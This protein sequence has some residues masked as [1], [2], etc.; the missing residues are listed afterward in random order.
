MANEQQSGLQRSRISQAGRLRASIAKQRRRRKRALAKVSFDGLALQWLAKDLRSDRQ[1]VLAAVS[2][3]GSAL[4]WAAKALRSDQEIV[5]AAV[6]TFGYALRFAAKALMSDRKIVL[7]AVSNCGFALQF[8]KEQLKSDREVVLAAV[9]ESGFALVFAS[10]ELKR[11]REI[12]LA[13][14][15]GGRAGDHGLLHADD[16]LLEDDSFA[17]EARQSYYSFRVVAL[18]GRTCLV[19]LHCSEVVALSA[20][21]IY[22]HLMCEAR[23]KLGMGTVEPGEETLLFGAE[24][25][26]GNC[27]VEHWPGSPAP[28]GVVEYQLVR[29]KRA[30]TDIV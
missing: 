2:N 11:D 9:S 21:D 20:R 6:S 3:S 22:E 30:R 18:S 13:A 10:S 24:E 29:T 8:A 25:V 5:L 27:E 19:P 1:I 15:R 17:V 16:S 23:A 14:A 4:E 28:G 7:A 12:A 26:S